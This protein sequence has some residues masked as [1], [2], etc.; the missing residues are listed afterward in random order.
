MPLFKQLGILNL[1]GIYEFMIA[2]FMFKFREN[3]LPD[4]FTEMFTINRRIHSYSTRQADDYHVPD[5][6]LELKRRAVSVRGAQIWNN[7]PTD[8][9]NSNSLSIFKYALKRHLIANI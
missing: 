6:H 2:T 7:T 3:S 9:K 5:G 4:I 8:I 1:N